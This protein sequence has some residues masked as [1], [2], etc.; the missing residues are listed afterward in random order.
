MEDI[1]ELVIS[2]LFIPFESKYDNLHIKV[3]KIQSKILRLFLKI[4]LILIPVL[5]IIGLCCLLSYLIRG[6][7]I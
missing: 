5:L 4:L 2:V 7:W 3:N 6:Y 1:L